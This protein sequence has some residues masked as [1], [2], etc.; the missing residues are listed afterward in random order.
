MLG[1]QQ[2][3]VKTFKSW[4]VKVGT[5]NY[6]DVINTSFIFEAPNNPEF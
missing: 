2:N 5:P 6:P 4:Q 1:K 3:G